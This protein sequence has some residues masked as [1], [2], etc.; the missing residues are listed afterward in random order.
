MLKEQGSR[1]ARYQ[2]WLTG[3]ETYTGVVEGIMSTT[4]SFRITY[5]TQ[6]LERVRLLPPLSSVFQLALGLR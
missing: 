6:A 5:H 3:S 1:Q 2:A 4:L